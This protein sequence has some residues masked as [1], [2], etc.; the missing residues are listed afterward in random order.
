MIGTGVGMLGGP[1]GALTGAAIGHLYDD[2]DPRS[3]PCVEQ[4]WLG[5]CDKSAL[6]FKELI[7]IM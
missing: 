1:I 3:M 4:F 5:V 6:N 7:E 2:D